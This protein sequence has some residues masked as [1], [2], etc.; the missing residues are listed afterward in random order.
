MCPLTRQ[1]WG[2]PAAVCPFARAQPWPG[3]RQ[4][5]Q[6]TPPC[7]PALQRLRCWSG[8]GRACSASPAA[9]GAQRG[10]DPP[11]PWQSRRV[12][13]TRGAVLISTAE[14]DPCLISA[15]VQATGKQP[16]AQ[17]QPLTAS[18]F[19][20]SIFPAAI[21]RCQRSQVPSRV[22]AQQLCPVA[23]RGPLGCT[24]VCP[25]M[26]RKIRFGCNLPSQERKNLSNKTRF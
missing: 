8:A 1:C 21:P 19:L 24:G 23:L 11:S 5:Q 15:C 17:T 3:V 25:S 7:L 22:S 10:R 12:L 16:Q 9:Q 14:P 4:K 20:G 6:H 26:E 18:I 2:W 13:G